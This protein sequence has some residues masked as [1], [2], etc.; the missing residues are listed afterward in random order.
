MTRKPSV[1]LTL[2]A[3]LLLVSALPALAQGEGPAEDEVLEGRV[4]GVSEDPSYQRLEFGDARFA[5]GGKGRR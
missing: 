1:L 3:L 5:G 2:S 4:V